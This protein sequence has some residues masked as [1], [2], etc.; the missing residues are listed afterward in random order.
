MLPRNE[1]YILSIKCPRKVLIGASARMDATSDVWHP[2]LVILPRACLSTV[3]GRPEAPRTAKKNGRFP[4]R[5]GLPGTVG[6]L[7][8]LGGMSRIKGEAYMAALYGAIR[9][10]GLL[11]GR[12]QRELF[13][14]RARSYPAPTVIIL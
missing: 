2:R 8:R 11:F 13:M 1:A 4:R 7:G 10:E 12:R 5:S 3:P 9:L 14:P 6:R